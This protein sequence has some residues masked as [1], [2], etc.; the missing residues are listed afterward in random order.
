[1]QNE[2]RRLLTKCNFLLTGNVDKQETTH[3]HTHTHTN[4][5]TKYTHE[6]HTKHTHT[7][8]HTHKT[9]TTHTIA[10]SE[11]MIFT[12][13]LLHTSTAILSY[14]CHSAARSCPYIRSLTRAIPYASKVVAIAR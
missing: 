9:H 10:F 6:I 12:F 3:T 13:S 4:I 14:F 5:H 2:K 7:H 11:L 1:M 8:K